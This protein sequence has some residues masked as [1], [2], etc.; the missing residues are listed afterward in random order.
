M[1]LRSI[2]IVIPSDQV[3]NLL[4]NVYYIKKH[5]V[6]LT[7]K[8]KKYIPEILEDVVNLLISKNIISDKEINDIIRK[9]Q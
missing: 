6:R 4:F 2:K 8:E 1:L 3:Q 9:Y 7:D 5:M